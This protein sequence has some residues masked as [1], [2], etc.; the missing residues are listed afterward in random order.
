VQIP[1]IAGHRVTGRIAVTVGSSAPRAARFGA[2]SFVQRF[3]SALNAHTHLHCCVTDRMF[4]VDAAG[5]LHFHPRANLDAAALS[6]VQRRIRSRVMRL[7]VRH[8]AL[9]PEVAADLARWGHG[10]GFSLHAAVL[11]EATDRA[12]LEAEG[13]G[14]AAFAFD[15]SPSWD[16][17]TPPPDPGFSFDQT[18][19]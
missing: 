1:S 13:V 15:Q 10:G 6:A 11:I 4:S 7:A 17:I 5:S 19:N 16:P 2:V 3:G 9:T 8:G 12:E 14:T 18:L